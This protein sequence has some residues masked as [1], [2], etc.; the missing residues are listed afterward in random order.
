MLAREKCECQIVSTGWTMALQEVFRR[1]AQDKSGATAIEY[2][3]I[4]S[5]IVIGMLV[6]LSAMADA[7]TSQ[8]AMVA[9]EAT[10]AMGN[11]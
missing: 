10:T 4:A 1:I 9:D 11:T 8:G 5:L 6:G 3:L 2:G 7:N